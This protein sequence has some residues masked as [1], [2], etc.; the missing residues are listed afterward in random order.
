M[1]YA[2][3]LTGTA[4]HYYGEGVYGWGPVS[5]TTGTAGRLVEFALE[6]EAHDWINKRQVFCA[7]SVVVDLEPSTADLLDGLRKAKEEADQAS[8]DLSSTVRLHRFNRLADQLGDAFGPVPLSRDEL[9]AF[10]ADQ[11][12][13]IKAV[14]V[15]DSTTATAMIDAAYVELQQQ[16][17]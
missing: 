13:R 17:G 1:S 8:A 7:G 11:V 6:S 4:L 12:E 16:H 9:L 3:Q 14:G 10:L 15:P 2:I 5:S